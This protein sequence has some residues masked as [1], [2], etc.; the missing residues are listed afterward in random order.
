M[1]TRIEALARVESIAFLPIL[2][3]FVQACS[4][5]QK[6]GGLGMA[7]QTP[8]EAV[9]TLVEAV[10]AEDPGKIES[11]LGPEGRDL[12]YSGDDI[13]DRS[14]MEHFLQVFGEKNHIEPAADDQ[15]ILHVGELDW[16]FPIPIVKRDDRWYFD[17]G[18]GKEEILNRRIGKNE[19]NAIQVCLA[20]VDAQREYA[21]K[22][23]DGD[24]ILEYAQIF[25]STPGARDGLYWEAKGDEEPSPL[26]PLA[27]QA[28]REGYGKAKGPKDTDEP[29]PYHGYLYRILEAQG[30]HAPGGAY[31][32]VVR[33][34]MIGGFALLAYPAE[35]GVSGIMS[36]TVN[37]DGVV[38]QKDLGKDTEKVAL[39]MRLFD[40]DSTWTKA[41]Q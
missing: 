2:A 24:G 7:F 9:R 34:K 37:H 8:E 36:F 33:G 22:D 14:G 12:V 39:E 18:A 31:E 41:S 29:R 40:P 1:K 21:Q 35:H 3:C 26:G 13:A 10:R 38:F 23:R 20:I 28:V 17:T 4:S 6:A 25:K 32:Y 11:V 15:V 30:E 5:G 27:A 16:P 19:L